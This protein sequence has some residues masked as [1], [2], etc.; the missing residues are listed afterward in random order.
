M[1]S[2]SIVS[3]LKAPAGFIKNTGAQHFDN[4]TW[5]YH[6]Q[7]PSPHNTIILGGAKTVLAHAPRVW[8]NHG[9]DSIHPPGI[10]H[11]LATWP[12]NEV[13]GWPADD[14]NN[15]NHTGLALPALEGGA[16]TGVVSPTADDFPFVGPAPARDGHFLAAGFNGHGMPRI[17]IATAQLVPAVLESLGVK[18]TAPAMVQDFPPLPKPFVA[19][20]KRVELLQDFDVQAEYELEVESHEESAKKAFCTGERNVAWKAQD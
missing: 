16:W 2:L 8:L 6:L 3:A 12:E 11:Y 4:N 5:N 13:V 9:D 18:W 14:N 17:L 7:L 10:A 15:N 20:A 19:T 1:P